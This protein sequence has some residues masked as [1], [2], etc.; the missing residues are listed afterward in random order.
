MALN[1]TIYKIILHVAN[2][3]THYYEKHSLTMAKHPSETDERLM[4]RLL[5]FALYADETLAFGKDIGDEREPSL[6]KRDLSGDIELWIE[7]GL[8]AERVI[9]KAC[10]R[11]K[12]AVLLIYGA[13]ADLWWRNNQ[14]EFVRK[15]NLSVFQLP[16][17]DTQSLAKMAKRSMDIT[18]TLEDGLVT[19]M[20][21]Q[22]ILH[23]QPKAL[24]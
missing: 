1:A 3:D 22:Q 14:K 8:P 12:K 19:L 5:A 2:M 4:V 7:L 15:S 23:I 18:C 13:Q 9:R 10:S 6:W 21:G 11:A 20:D 17:P 16:Y 24:L